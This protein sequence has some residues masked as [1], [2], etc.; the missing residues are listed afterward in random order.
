MDTITGDNS[1][2]AAR[3]RLRRTPEASR[4]ALLD[5]AQSLGIAEGPAAVY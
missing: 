1:Q 2:H 5:M 4:R 3:A